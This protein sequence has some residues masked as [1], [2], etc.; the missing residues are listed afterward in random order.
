MIRMDVKKANNIQLLN[1]LY[2]FQGSKVKSKQEAIELVKKELK[3]R[4][5][6]L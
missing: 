3:A 4:G 2:T 5:V 6:I 1:A